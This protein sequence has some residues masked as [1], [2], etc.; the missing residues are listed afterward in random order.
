[1]TSIYINLA[2][3][4]LNKS[5]AFYRDLG[6]TFDSRFTDETGTMMNISHDIKVM[7]LTRDRF[8]EFT[9]RT[10]V[11]AHFGV[12]CLNSLSMPGKTEI[13]EMMTQ[14]LSLGAKE[15]MPAQ[16]H[17]FMYGRVFSDLDGHTWDLVWMDST[18]V[19]SLGD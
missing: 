14:A 2:V 18:Y 15:P 6:F 13:D 11:D 10:I 12:E 17:G 5:V 16:D 4:D 3:K 9:P 8:Q 7:L 19:D 1:M